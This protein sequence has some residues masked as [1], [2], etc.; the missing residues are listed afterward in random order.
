MKKMKK[1]FALLIA[2][3]MVLGMSTSVFAQTSGTQSDGTGSI[4]INNPA[5]GQTYSVYKL[6]DATLGSNGEVAYK[7]T[8]PATM[9]DYFEETS[10]G[11][12]YV[13][14]KPAA[15][16]TVKYY[17]DATKTTVS[18]EATAY[19]TGEGMSTGLESAL[20]TWAGTASATAGPVTSDGSDP[21]TF[22]GL[23]YGYYVMVTSHQDH[24]KAKAIISVDTT[25]PNV[26][27]N[28]KNETKI[29]AEKKEANGK[30]FSIGEA[31]TFTATF[32][33]TNYY[34]SGEDAGKIYK[35]V[36]SDTLPA[37]LSNVTVTSITVGGT[38]IT[39]QQFDSNKQI[40]IPWV[41]EETDASLY[42]N[43]AK[44][45]VTYTAKLTSTV[46]VNADNKNTIDI[47][48]YDKD[49]KPYSNPF[50]T[51]EEITTYAAALKKTDGTKALAGAKFAFNGLT[52][53]KT[54]DGVYTVVSYDATS[55]TAGTE[56]E[57][58]SN[59]KLYI[60]GLKAGVTLTGKETEA[61]V[62]Y[63]KLTTDVT[64]TP[65]VLETEVY[66]E[67]GTRYYDADGNL[68]AQ[69]VTGG[70]SKPVTNNL[71]DLDEAAVEVVNNAGAELPS[72]GGIGTTIFYIIGAIL[73]IGAGVVLVTRRRMNAR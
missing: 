34:G 6:F 27:I 69:E 59:G 5:K 56:M 26:T 32:T 10:T 42:A 63:N 13:Q 35:Y 7:G 37:Y 61:P 1:I 31:I 49:D 68:V 23:P 15:F 44:I 54:A 62:G 14:A 55:T 60:V 64:L 36:I 20:E 2:M 71:S 25:Q 65:Q 58:D 11:S 40:T 57:V 12:G 72:T 39:T 30:S 70:S 4:A 8:V 52:V 53:E 18:E 50:E 19:W 22:Y 41:D 48:P 43:G 29:V 17:T 33:T 28:D 51:S 47:T 73:V 46:N 24:E 67:S 3:V 66:K 38:A 21:L 16:K 9:T 45:V